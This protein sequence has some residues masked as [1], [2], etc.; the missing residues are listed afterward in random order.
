MI[1]GPEGSLPNPDPSL[2]K[3]AGSRGS[4]SVGQSYG[5]ADPDPYQIVMD[6]QHCLSGKK[7][8]KNN[9]RIDR[10]EKKKR[11][12]MTAQEHRFLKIM[13]N[14]GKMADNMRHYIIFFPLNHILFLL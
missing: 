5:S 4:E 1:P 3:I 8:N 13:D 11:D 6:P 9:A 2:T 14:L 12:K 7:Y 10:G